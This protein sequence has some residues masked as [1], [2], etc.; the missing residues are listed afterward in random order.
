MFFVSLLQQYWYRLL[1]YLSNAQQQKAKPWQE[2]LVVWS[3]AAVAGFVIVLF[4]RLFDHALDTF[5]TIRHHFPHAYLLLSP[6]G[7]MV[8][9]YI[10]RRWFQGS[11][12]S[13]IPQVIACL[14]EPSFTEHSTRLVSLRIALGKITLSSFAVLFGFS[15][16]REGPSVQISASIMHAFGRLLPTRS[17]ISPHQLLLAGGAAGIAAAFNTPLA[18]IVFAIEELAKQFEQRTNGV[19]LTAI[20]IA[21]M[22]STSL[23]G[24]YLYFGHLH[25]IKTSSAIVSPVLCSAVVC[26][27]LGGLFSQIL[28]WSSKQTPQNIWRYK[29]AN[30]VIF[31]GVCGIGISI[32]SWLS[33]A[34]INGSGYNVTRDM[35]M[36]GT[37][38]S[39][40]Y[41]PMKALATLL[42]YFSGVPGGIFAPALSIGAGIGNDVQMLL[43][44]AYSSHVI[45]ALCMAGFLSAVTQAP[46]T[47]AI[48]VM[49]MIDGHELVL[50]LVAV[51]LLSSMISRKF[52]PPLYHSLSEPM[53]QHP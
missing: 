42:S 45:Y 6:L 35:V 33:H 40:E 52:S 19:M 25:I 29:H 21:G 5:F 12:G 53:K 26:G 18:G 48:I 15:T 17:R 3:G 41:A 16:G 27:I 14:N 9:V 32:L 36:H 50:S 43:G 51:T 4:V 10:T 11:Q 34:E 2:R 49:E 31:A 20:V 23:Q 46:I 8:V 13:G 37:T 22:V 47:S 30:P 44:S 24:N 1:A 39:W 38:M 7:G 28:I